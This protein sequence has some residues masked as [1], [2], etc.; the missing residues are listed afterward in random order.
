MR[1]VRI[2]LIGAADVSLLSGLALFG[3][4][5]TLGIVSAITTLVYCVISPAGLLIILAAI[6]HIT[7]LGSVDENLLRITK[8]GITSFFL[9]VAILRLSQERSV[10]SYG[11]NAVEKSFLLLMAWAALCSLFAIKPGA[12]AGEVIRLTSLLPIYYLARHCLRTPR[13][14][15][16][17]LF[18]ILGAVCLASLASAYQFF[19]LGIIRVRGMYGNANMLGIFL[20]LT[21]PGLAIGALLANRRPVRILYY[22]GVVAGFGALLLS[23]SRDGYLCV[24]T[25]LLVYLIIERKKRMLAVLATAAVVLIL[26]ILATPSL[27]T[28]AVESL[29]LKGGTTHRTVLWKHGLSAF[30]DNPVFGLGFEVPKEEVTGRIQWNSFV[31]FLLYSNPETRFMPHNTYIY[32]LMSLGLPGLVL[33]LFLYRTM[34]KRQLELRRSASKSNY[35][36]VHS[37]MIALVIGT[38]AYG[39]FETSSIF[40]HGSWANYFWI[41]LGLSES[42]GLADHST[43]ANGHSLNLAEEPGRGI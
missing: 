2:W 4:L 32:A 42:K 18:T 35:R 13:D 29:R 27:R 41:L 16:I 39:M 38:L 14:L 43:S 7:Q 9:C 40:G 8:W 34:L 30:I 23:W 3:P 21:L 5:A 24:A 12:S 28:I 37:I 6:S 17:L 20:G 15:N 36:K 26:V 31:E 22:C 33:L 25:Q 11:L 10:S 1:N 19:E